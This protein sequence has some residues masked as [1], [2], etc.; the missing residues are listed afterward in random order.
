MINLL[1]KKEGKKHQM[2]VGDAREYTKLFIRELAVN[3]EARVAFDSAF[4]KE[5]TKHKNKLARR[6]AVA[7]LKKKT[8]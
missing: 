6:E 3:D 7:N 8:K 1:V 4:Q 2:Q 5:L